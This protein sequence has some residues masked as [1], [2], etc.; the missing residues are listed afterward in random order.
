MIPASGGTF[1]HNLNAAR[2]SCKNKGSRSA[3][4]TSIKSSLILTEDMHSFITLH[5]DSKLYG[6]FLRVSDQFVV[7]SMHSK[8]VT[9]CSGTQANIIAYISR[10]AGDLCTVHA[11]GIN[12]DENILRS[13]GTARDNEA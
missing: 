1:E 10:F 4:R 5:L 2:M 12:P 13:Q 8:Q 6:A 3:T 7:E 9:S 11:S